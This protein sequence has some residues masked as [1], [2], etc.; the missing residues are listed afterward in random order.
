M[1]E[2]IKKDMTPDGAGQPE[3]AVTAPEER[4]YRYLKTPRGYEHL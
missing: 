2:E 4:Q 1:S 3:E